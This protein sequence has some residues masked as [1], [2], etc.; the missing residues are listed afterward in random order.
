M[1]RRFRDTLPAA[2]RGS[3]QDGPKFAEETTGIRKVQE[4][5][6]GSPSWGLPSWEL[7]QKSTLGLVAGWGWPKPSSAALASPAVAQYPSRKLRP[8]QRGQR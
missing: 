1:A 8:I 6:P 2:L 4:D 7:L 3:C 5:F